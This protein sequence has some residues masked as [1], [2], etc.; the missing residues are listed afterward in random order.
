MA[1]RVTLHANIRHLVAADA[2]ALLLVALT[3]FALTLFRFLL[4]PLAAGLLAL[5][6]AALFAA[7]ILL[8]RE[9]GIQAVELDEQT[10]TVYR[11]RARAARSLPRAAVAR[12]R[13]ARRLGWRAV[14]VYPR[15]GRRVR[16]PEDAFPREEFI[17]LCDDLRSWK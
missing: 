8:W 15:S 3:L 9:R 10:L 16:I 7:R 14:L 17:R 1:A 6:C 13:I 11:G 2:A 4:S 5:L 12:V